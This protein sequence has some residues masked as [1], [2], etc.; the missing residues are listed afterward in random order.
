LFWYESIPGDQRGGKNV[1]SGVKR[2][3]LMGEHINDLC[4][5]NRCPR[6][7]NWPEQSEGTEGFLVINSESPEGQGD[8]RLR[9]I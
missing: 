2:I 9:R 7:P 3:M 8:Q 1:L 6:T 5:T 4:S